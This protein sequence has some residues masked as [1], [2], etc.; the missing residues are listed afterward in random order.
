M[1][2]LN[3]IQSY[4]TGRPN[5]IDVALKKRSLEN[6]ESLLIRVGIMS[7]FDI[8]EPLSAKRTGLSKRFKDPGV[9]KVF[10]IAVV[11]DVPE[12]YEC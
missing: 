11:P 2:T 5:V 7:I 4:C 8:D 6:S 3:R 10:L 9:K 1:S 12:N